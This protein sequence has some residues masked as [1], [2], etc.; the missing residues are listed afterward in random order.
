MISVIIPTLNE[1]KL[2]PRLLG[3]L[4]DDLRKR[5]RIE[6]IVSDGGSRDKTLKIA[7]Q[8]KAKIVKKYDWEKQTIGSARN[9]GAWQ[10]SGDILVFIDADGYIQNPWYFF[11]KIRDVFRDHNT[12]AA[13]VKIEVM[14]QEQKPIDKLWS[15]FFNSLFYLENKVAMGGM[16]RGNCQ[17]VRADV[18]RLIGGYNEK[19]A[20][21]EDYD[22][23]HRLRQ[24]GN[25]KFLWQVVVYESPRRFRKHGYLQVAWLWT[26][27]SISV[28]LTGRAWS[29]QWKRV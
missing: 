20:A 14:P 27:N 17:I 16:G 15:L 13:T 6:V 7:R 3:Q 19:L 28:I 23:Y 4:T 22:L 9:K 18:F 1:E 12:V 8:Q 5:F 26:L 11:S 29:K 10:A 24:I 21:A 25:I 2:L